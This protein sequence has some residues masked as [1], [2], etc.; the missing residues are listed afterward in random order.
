MR[1]CLCFTVAALMAGCSTPPSPPASPTTRLEAV[2]M[3]I[4]GPTQTAGPRS[5]AP[6]WVQDGM[7]QV[8]LGKPDQAIPPLLKTLEVDPTHGEAHYWLMQAYQKKADSGLAQEH[9]RQVVKLMPN[10]TQADEAQAL[11]ELSTAPKLE[12]TGKRP[13]DVKGFEKAK[14]GMSE[15]QIRQIYQDQL[16]PFRGRYA[17][18]R[19]RVPFC[20]QRQ[21]GSQV[22]DVLLTFDVD[23]GLLSGVYI[24][25]KNYPSGSQRD[26]LEMLATLTQLYG[27]P[28]A[29]DN[30]EGLV[31]RL[32]KVW[33]FPSA[34]VH[35]N[36][37]GGG[38]LSITILRPL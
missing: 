32:R 23:D 14:L 6:K 33:N 30:L 31:E 20:L 36:L 8:L 21:F 10:T 4:P 3:A 15:P 16:K 19:H 18:P 11:L 35:L 22:M 29:D 27:P 9:A 24:R 13:T 2:S 5:N 12:G 17:N 38:D 26:F 37:Y 34:R 28:Q 25:P 1:A 7:D